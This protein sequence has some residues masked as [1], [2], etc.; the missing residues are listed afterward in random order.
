M[1]IFK[2][3][4]E[5]Y[6]NRNP[7]NWNLSKHYIPKQ[8]NSKFIVHWDFGII[9]NFPFEKYPLQNE[10]L[11]DMNKR[12]K[13]E[14]ELNILLKDEKKYKSIS[15]IDIANRF[16]VPYS[17]KTTTLIPETPG[18]ILLENLTLLKL[19]QSIE[20]LTE[21]STLNL[22]IY[23]FEYHRHHFDLKKE[24]RNIT[25]DKYFEIQEIFSFELDTCLFSENLDWC[26]T[27]AED[28]A[29]L[30]GCKKEN[31]TTIKQKMN[32]ELFKIENEQ[33]MY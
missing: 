13:I 28:T 9:D 11:E 21:H 12:V 3:F 2:D 32:L 29:I 17:H 15:I 33:E 26:I 10:T 1:N 23:D 4:T 20:K 19:R 14:Q 22:L 7:D 24:Y 30:L 27:T 5:F 8:F 18:V 25:L 16:K 6:N 31:E